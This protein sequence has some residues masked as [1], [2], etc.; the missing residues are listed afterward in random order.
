M[1]KKYTVR[2][3]EEERS[4][5]RDGNRS[6]ICNAAE[7]RQVSRWAS[8][9]ICLRGVMYYRHV[10]REGEDNCGEHIGRGRVARGID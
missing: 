7:Q 5:L 1:V 10:G 3:S 2:L 4:L 8:L 9:R 6:A